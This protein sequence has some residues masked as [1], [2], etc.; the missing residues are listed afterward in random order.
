MF[1]DEAANS[2][3]WPGRKEVFQPRRGAPRVLAGLAAE[4]IGRPLRRAG[5]QAQVGLL[6][7]NPGQDKT[8]APLAVICEFTKRPSDEQMALA[9]RLA[10]NFCRTR[11][12]ITTERDRLR[13]WTCC[14]PPTAD[15]ATKNVF[16]DRPSKGEQRLLPSVSETGAHAL[17]WVNLVSGEFFRQRENS[18]KAEGKADS[19]LLANLEHVR[20]E[21]LDAKLPKD[22]C[23]D[24]LARL[25]F[26]QFLFQRKDKQG[27]PCLDEALLRRR[28]DGTLSQY[29][30]NLEEILTSVEDTYALFRWLNDRFNGDLFPGKA[31]TAADREKEWE[32]EKTE[33]KSKHLRLLADFV[34]GKMHIQKGQPTLWQYYSFDTIPL[35]F[36]SSVYEQFVS[37]DAHHT[38]AYYTPPFLV[39]FVLDTVLPWDSQEWNVRIL[40]PACG[41]GIFLV[42]AFQ[43]LIHR[44]KNANPRKEPRTCD[45]KPILE[46]NLLGV[47]INKDAARVASFSLYLAMCDAIDP[48]HYWKQIVFPR[49]R[50]KRIFAKDFFDDHSQGFCSRKDRATYDLVVGNPPWGDKTVDASEF[51]GT[52]MEQHSWE[53]TNGDIGPL[54]LAK[55]SVLAK[56][57]AT[58]SLLQPATV[59]LFNRSPTALE[60]RTKIFSEYAV[61]EVVNLSAL[62]FELFNNAVGPSCVITLENVRPTPGATLEYLC[63]KPLKS[64]DDKFRIVIEPRD[65]HTVRLSEAASNELVWTALAWGGGRDVTFL[66]RLRDCRTLQRMEASKEIQTREGI[67]RGDRMKQQ[68]EILN[69]PMLEKPRFPEGTFLRL[70]AEDLDRNRDTNT[71]SAASTDFRAFNPPQMILKQT[72]STRTYRIQAVVVAPTRSGEGALCTQ[73]YLTVHAESCQPEILEAAC[74]SYNSKLAVYFLLLSSGRFAAYRQEPLVEDLMRIPLPDPRPGLLDGLMTPEEVDERVRALF[75]LKDS[76]WALVED[77][78]DFTLRD[79]KGGANSPGRQ[80]T[81]RNSA[82]ANGH[83]EPDLRL[84]TEQFI[85][86]LKAG[87]GNDKRICATILQEPSSQRLPVRVVAVHLD[88]P[89]HAALEIEKTNSDTLL[90][91]LAKLYRDY[92]KASDKATGF[93]FERSAR[94]YAPH[95]TNEGKVPTIFLIK[96]DQRRQWTSSMAMRDADEVAAEIMRAQWK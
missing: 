64:S 41:S 30:Q 51:V 90:Q 12:L 36:I 60:L 18:F 14:K 93:L 3:G 29:Y 65:I 23:H 77:L 5:A 53:T 58:V 40:D 15:E 80:R 67:I 72:W 79:F 94:L 47:D 66:H 44:W 22:I 78:V 59:L 54:F 9:H 63:P 87:F 28:F 85:R 74:L 71:D 7:T 81:M 13:A 32:L 1:F 39:D 73:S 2:L 92:M 70:K 75:G 62:R 43:R 17:H 48:R 83:E 57:G 26:A 95:R 25:I 10:W 61:K 46:K 35:E 33:V 24:L 21:L 42:K 82:R 76:E 88:W 11:L 91:R 8:E 34:S 69:W 45:L 37:E 20:K 56:K 68:Q 38:K 96:P 86:V 19:L 27:K 52:W 31:E 55:A 84:Y 49:L 16:D 6:P 50:D 89:G 4:K